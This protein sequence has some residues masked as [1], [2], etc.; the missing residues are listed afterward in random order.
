MEQSMY[1]S[2][3]EIDL[4][5]VRE[6][7][8]KVQRRIGKQKIIPVLKADA[9]GLGAVRMAEFYVRTIGAEAVAVAQTFEGHELR[10]A[11]FA[12]LDILLLSAPPAQAIPYALA[13][14]LVIP[15]FRAED[16]R[17]IDAEAAR[18][19][20][21]AKVQIKLDTGMNRIGVRVGAPLDG[22][23]D[24]LRALPRLDV[25]SVMTHF[26]NATVTGDPFTYTQFEL[27]RQ[28]VTQVRAAGFEPK[29]VHC[30][31]SGAVQW[32]DED[33]CTHVRP[34]SLLT[35]YHSMDDGTNAL[36][37]RE[38]LSWRAFVTNVHDIQPGESVG[39]CHHFV[40]ERPMTVATVD[41]G[42]ADGLFRPLAQG[43]GPVLLNDARTRFLACSMDQ[44]MIDATGLACAVGDQV[45][46]FGRSPSGLAEL[47]LAEVQQHTHQALSLCQC[48]LSRRVQRVYKD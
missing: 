37:M 47:P 39:Y 22:L 23:L 1:H 3:L 13:D 17:L 36:E 4:S 34:G 18:Q 41:I 40:A 6:A 2:Y 5:R 14:G 31:N 12:D 7:C 9:Y 21:R 46:M 27:F 26:V 11:G 30:R 48:L 15:V 10:E 43:G 38:S 45:T 29:Y 28:G 8:G 33:F 42:F 19:G 44:T 25:V 35:G 32:F 16:A 24:A 20:T